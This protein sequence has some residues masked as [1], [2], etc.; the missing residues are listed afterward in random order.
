MALCFFAPGAMSITGENYFEPA[1]GPIHLDEVQC[2]GDEEFL[3]N[4]SSSEFSEHDCIHL[5][6]A[7]VNCESKAFTLVVLILSY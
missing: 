1:S 3:V 2:I 5:E 7:G 6:D 4:C